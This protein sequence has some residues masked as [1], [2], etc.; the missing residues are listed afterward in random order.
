MQYFKRITNNII[1][2]YKN[3]LFKKNNTYIYL[4]LFCCVHFSVYAQKEIEPPSADSIIEI[5]NS[6]IF[7]EELKVGFRFWV[8]SISGNKKYLDYGID[9][10]SNGNIYYWL[11][12]NNKKQ[13]VNVNVTNKYYLIE[14]KTFLEHYKSTTSNKTQEKLPSKPLVPRI[15][16]IAPPNGSDFIEIPNSEIFREQGVEDSSTKRIGFRR[17]GPDGKIENVNVSFSV[18]SEGNIYEWIWD[19]KGE[20]QYV[21]VTDRTEEERKTIE[22]M[23]SMIKEMKMKER[24]EDAA[25]H[26]RSFIFICILVPTLLIPPLCV[27]YFRGRKGIRN[28]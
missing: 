6:E 15:P 19:S 12:V 21:R 20:K 9:Y 1:F 3:I 22:R 13:Y 7:F 28:I 17:Y 8:K 16:S 24:Q 14:Y 11:D 25:L 27:W 5:P 18:D 23:Q 4:I 10:D 2:F 26:R